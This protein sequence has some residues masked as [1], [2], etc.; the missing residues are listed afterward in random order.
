MKSSTVEVIESG[1]TRRL[2]TIST[3]L[4]GACIVLFIGW[5]VFT[6]VDEIAKA[7]GAVIPEGERQVIQSELGGK[8]KTIFVK[9]GQLVE[10]GDSIVE[11]DA[12]FQ[13]SALEELNSKEATL[14]LSIERMTALIEEREPDFTQYE[15]QYPEV[16]AEQRAELAATKSL[17]FKKRVV[18]EKE[19]ERIAE[20][21]NG[22]DRQIPSEVRQLRSSQK[23]LNILIKGQKSGSISQVR[24]LEMRQKIASIETELEQAKA[25]KA[26]LI[27][28]A[29]SNQSKIEQLLAE[30]KLE[31]SKER[32]KAVS[33]L[34][35]LNARLRSGEAKVSNTLVT[36]PVKGLVQ[37]LPTTR[38][39]G[40]IKPGGT[41]VE[42]VPVDGR[43][44]F[45]AKLSPRDVGFVSVGQPA[46]V[47]VDAFDYSRFGALKGT[48][49]E[50]S[51]TTSQTDRG[52]IY[53]DVFVQVEKGYFG[54]DPARFIIIPGMTGE[55]DITTGEKTVFQYLWKP[56]Y[57]NVSR[58]FG[59]R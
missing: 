54:N 49:T 41:V 10:I 20:E 53:Y 22:V 31:V 16:V 18:L 33:E 8:L 11:F 46:R 48:V 28:Q 56:I 58:A 50:I 45:K 6:K 59:E 36:S 29:E 9:R 30:A 17:Y 27:K 12:T 14:K 15:T 19:S 2:L 55:V 39:G 44:A 34:S 42:I 52:E 24:V 13:T 32:S 23:E 25:K 4:I 7:K 26:V 43:A 5:T 37:S 47:K 3:L 1:I 38:S 40:V 21:L 51:P 57:T 35:A